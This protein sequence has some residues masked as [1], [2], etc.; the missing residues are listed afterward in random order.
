MKKQVKPKYDT[1]LVIMNMFQVEESSIH[2]NIGKNAIFHKG[3]ERERP[4]KIV[5]VQKIWDYDV[6]GN[7]SFGC[8]GYTIQ[9]ELKNMLINGDLI[10]LS[11]H[12]RAVSQNDLTI[13]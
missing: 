7:Y 1:D 12:W 6:N 2:M 11:D 10:P 4:V 5:G 13:E 3:T 9:E 8:F